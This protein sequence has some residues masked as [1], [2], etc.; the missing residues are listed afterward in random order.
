[1]AFL[2]NLKQN[3][4]NWLLTD[5]EFNTAK[6]KRLLAYELYQA[7]YD[8][9][10]KQQLKTGQ[11]QADDNVTL[12]FSKLVVDRSV[13][14]LLGG[15]IYFDM[16]DASDENAGE[17]E[18]E[19]QQ[20]IDALWSANKQDI[21]LHKSAMS[22]S[23]RGTGA[24]KIIPDTYE[25]DGTMYPRLISIDT[26]FLDIQTL[27]DDYETVEAYIIGYKRR[28]DDGKEYGYKEVTER[29]RDDDG[30][31]LDMWRI[32]ELITA[33]GGTKW[34]EISS[35]EWNYE[36]PPIIHWQN[37]PD[38]HSV[39]GESDMSGII[40]LQDRI[41]FV[42][43]NISKIIRF[44]AHPKTWAAGAGTIDKVAWGADDMV[45]FTSSDARIG[46]LEMQNDLQSSAQFLEALRQ[47]LFDISRT[48]DIS[49]MADRIGQLTN[50]GLRVLYADSLAKLETKRDIFGEA[51]IQ[52][53]HRMLVLAGIEPDD[54]G[55]IVWPEILPENEQEAATSDGFDL[56]NGLASKRTISGK[57]GY[58]YAEEQARIMSEKE[59][60]ETLGA[61]LLQAF[62]NG[63]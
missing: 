47:A 12:N 51:L 21:F 5:D 58:D 26:R 7:Y 45:T 54:G 44:H 6:Q 8:G 62:N 31:F 53:N 18:G 52:L 50:F 32:R 60:E 56:A 37:L 34:E 22:A 59:Q 20:Y 14:M 15:G 42:A 24:I 57:R 23:I 48:T 25:I 35:Q 38:P 63:Q 17:D 3:L 9:A 41:N 28:T 27:P 43:S 55:A 30:Q 19:N 13:A 10:Q 39:Y 46:N 40:G 4:R 16:P 29:V 2:D 49:S 11:G 33:P 36:F 61:L 1:M